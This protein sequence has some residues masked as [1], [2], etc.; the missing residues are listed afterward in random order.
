METKETIR[1]FYNRIQG[2]IYT[3]T[4]TGAQTARDFYNRILGYWDPKLN[5]TRDF[6]NRIIAKGN[7]LAALIYQED[8]KQKNGK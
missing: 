3:D 5:V 4:A 8:A 1:D 2:Y 6:Y 7:V